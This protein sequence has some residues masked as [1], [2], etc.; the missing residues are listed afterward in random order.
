V[1]RRILR[2]PH[3]QIRSR[4]IANYARSAGYCGVVVFS[5]GNSAKALRD[6][7]LAVLEIGP[8]GD[9]QSSRWWT[10]AEVHRSWPDLLDATSGH[11]PLPLMGDI[12][13]AFRRH[14]GKLSASTYVVPSGSG[15]TICCLRAAYPLLKFE[16]A[17]DSSRPET[18]WHVSA[19][20]NAFVKGNVRLP[21]SGRSHP[22]IS[23]P[24]HR[25]PV[26]DSVPS[27]R[28]WDEANSR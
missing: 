22:G 9:L 24:S 6:Q 1:K 5:C 2:F 7:G 21:N 28:C 12:A 3:K 14:L 23:S 16:A 20:L 26:A 8:R 18:E 4:V 15:E 25:F 19:P 17:Y 10:L 11:L 27:F 13:K